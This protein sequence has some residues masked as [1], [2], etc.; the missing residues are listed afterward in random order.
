MT[1]PMRF[2]S[3]EALNQ[4]P[5]YAD[6]D[7]FAT[8]RALGEAVQ[9]N[10]AAA[11]PAVAADWLPKIPSR[12]YD[13]RFRPTTLKSAVTLGMGMTEKQGGTDVRA[14]STTAAPAGDAY[15]INGHKWF[16]SAPMCDAF[17][18]LAQA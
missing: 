4:S 7:L 2:D 6:V 18:V 16:M 15:R 11:E 10:G 1:A 5:P 8:D 3:P 17:L 14:N 12:Q 13:A 9:A